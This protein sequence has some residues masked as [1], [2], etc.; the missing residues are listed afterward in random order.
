[1][2]WGAAD[3]AIPPNHGNRAPT[4]AIMLYEVTIDDQT[5]RLELVRSEEGWKCRLDGNEVE[6]NGVLARQDVLSLLIDGNAYE[7]KRERTP[8]GIYLSLGSRRYSAEVRDP[9]SLRG[10][11]R[12]GD[13]DQGLKKLLAPMPGIVVRLLLHENAQVEVGQG[14]L[15][16]EAMKM[17]N[18]VQSPKKGVVQKILVDVGAAVNAGD[19]LAIVE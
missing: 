8:T 12:R 16:V 13:D 2:I 7:I 10:R 3:P 18:E 19:V 1:M 4:L 6:V 15:V 11:R 5:Y 17:Q 14:V 9:R